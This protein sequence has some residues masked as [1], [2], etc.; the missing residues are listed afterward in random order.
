MGK[1]FNGLTLALLLVPR[2]AAQNQT[3]VPAGTPVTITVVPAAA[4]TPPVSI[5]LGSR[6]AHVTPRRS[7]FTHTGAGNIDVAQPSADTIVI[8]MT[9]VAVAGAHPCRASSAALDFDLGQSF[10]VSF[11]NPKVKKAK[12]A[13]EGRIIGL[14]RSHAKGGG[15]A[16]EGPGCATVTVDGKVLTTLTVSEHSVTCGENLSLND[17]EGPVEVAV[18]PGKFTLHQTFTV[19]AGHP[20]SLLPCKA[21]S[22]EF[23]PDPALDPLWISYWEPFHGASKKDFGLQIT[24]KVSEDTSSRAKK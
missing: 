10:E 6:H 18:S 7:G 17:H 16:G 1:Y 15:S 2:L 13:I 22:A 11:D 9:G 4:A 23:A 3:H 5:S 14:L 8:T 21:A 20:R 12:L 24:L 19:W